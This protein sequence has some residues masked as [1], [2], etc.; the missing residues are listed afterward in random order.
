MPRQ[1]ST[2]IYFVVIPNTLKSFHNIECSNCMDPPNYLNFFKDIC[3]YQWFSCIVYV[4]YYHL[5]LSTC[6]IINDIERYKNFR[7]VFSFIRLF[8]FRHYYININPL[9]HISHILSNL[10]MILLSIKIYS[11]S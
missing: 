4:F 6:M 1:T 3:L 5:F 7:H 9:Y 10:C 11:I 2:K 8:C